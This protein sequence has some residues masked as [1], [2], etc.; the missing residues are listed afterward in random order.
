MEN[1]CPFIRDYCKN[2][3]V[4]RIAR[5][6]N[7]CRLEEAAVNINYLTGII[8]DKIDANEAERGADDD[9]PAP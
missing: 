3:C 8:S 1:F 4:F 9:K 6:D 7:C 5:N 2:D